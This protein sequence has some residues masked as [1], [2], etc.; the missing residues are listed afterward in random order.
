V[1]HLRH[2]LI[3]EQMAR[4]RIVGQRMPKSNEARR[5]ARLTKRFLL[6]DLETEPRILCEVVDTRLG[7]H[8]REHV[9]HVIGGERAVSGGAARMTPGDMTSQRGARL[10]PTCTSGGV[11]KTRCTAPSGSTRS[12]NAPFLHSGHTGE[13]TRYRKVLLCLSCGRKLAVSYRVPLSGFLE[14]DSQHRQKV[15]TA[16]G[17]M[18][19][20]VRG[21]ELDQGGSDIFDSY[22]SIPCGP[23]ALQL[24]SEV[25]P[26][27]WDP[28]A[29]R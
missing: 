7:D 2:H 12:W 23:T 13:G 29:Q 18:A 6:P 24:R 27:M 14:A 9:R 21:M 4:R 22:N 1:E 3:G 19:C 8:R 17:A 11:R 15:V 10:K 20:H 26:S 16:R 25:H 28:P 5:E